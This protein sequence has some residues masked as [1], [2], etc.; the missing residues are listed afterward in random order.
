MGLEEIY[1]ES[2][3]IL[4]PDRL[5]RVHGSVRLDRDLRRDRKALDPRGDREYRHAP[6]PIGRMPTDADGKAKEWCSDPDH[7]GYDE[8]GKDD[9]GWRPATE[10]G[11]YTD[12]HGRTRLRG[13]CNACRARRERLRR[14]SAKSESVWARRQFAS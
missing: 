7:E 13:A 9:L 5:T 14:L 10:F 3:H 11:E 6:I 1:I 2:E 8:H 4:A 12:R